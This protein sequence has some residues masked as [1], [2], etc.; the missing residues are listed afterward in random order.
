MFLEGVTVW[1]FSQWL[2]GPYC[3]MLLADLGATVVKVERPPHGDPSRHALP[4]VFWAANRGKAS[5]AVDYTQPLGQELIRGLIGP[6][7]VV[8]EGFRPGVMARWGL[9]YARL[10]PERPGLIY[11]AITGY[12]QTGDWAQRPGHDLNYLAQIGALALPGDF[13]Q[14]PQRSGIPVADLAGAMFAAVSIL[15][16]LQGRSRTGRGTF[17]DVAMTDAVA[18]WMTPRLSGLA[19]GQTGAHGDPPDYLLPT[20]RLY[21]TRDG[22]YLAL[23]IVEDKFWARWCLAADHPEWRDDPRWATATARRVHAR[24]LV[25]LLADAVASRDLVDWAQRLDAADVPWAPVQEPAGWL[26]DPYVQ[27]RSLLVNVG[28]ADAPQYQV[29]YPVRMDAAGLRPVSRPPDMGADTLAIL[30]TAGVD[31]TTL[32]DLVRK[33]VVTADAGHDPPPRREELI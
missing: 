17:L 15:A 12:G 16:A 30:R 24:A 26:N 10:A 9:D 2:P 25:A 20:N 1:D 4:G 11:C 28:T 23:G 19:C 22:A 14:P 31:E 3:T 8:V 32:R 27:S 29:R 13:D 21:R 5:V 33:G 18:S 6:N 7:D